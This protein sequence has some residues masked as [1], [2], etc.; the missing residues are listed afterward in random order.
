MQQTS[1]FD[2]T[3]SDHFA[4]N[5][6][7]ASQTLQRAIA[8][9]GIVGSIEGN[10]FDFT[11]VESINRVAHYVEFGNHCEFCRIA[12]DDE[13]AGSREFQFRPGVCRAW[14]AVTTDAVSIGEPGA[15]PT[16]FAGMHARK[17][18]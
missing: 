14:A 17:A 3:V 4:P 7:I 10:E 1:G 6:S 16:W 13:G 9:F 11:L 18:A 5:G 8:V 2:T 12:D 15:A